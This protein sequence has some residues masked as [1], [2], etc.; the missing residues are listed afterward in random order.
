M[1]FAHPPGKDS[2]RWPWVLFV[3]L[4]AVAVVSFGLRSAAAGGGEAPHKGDKKETPPP[5]GDKKDSPPPQAEKP[6]ANAQPAPTELDGLIELMEEMLKS[7]KQNP[8]GLTPEELQRI[9]QKSMQMPNRLPAPGQFGKLPGGGGLG[10]VQNVYVQRR[11]GA[12]VKPPSDTLSEQLNLPKGQG[13]VIV[14]V[15][16]NSSAAQAGLKP[17]DILLELNGQPVSSN[18]VE[19]AA[20]LAG[21]KSDQP[22]DAVVLRKGARQE[23]KGIKLTETP[24]LPPVAPGLP[25]N[26]FPPAGFPGPGKVIPVGPGQVLPGLPMQPGQG[27]PGGVKPLAPFGGFFEGE[28]TCDAERPDVR[29]GGYCDPY[30]LLHLGSSSFGKGATDA[31]PHPVSHVPDCVHRW[32]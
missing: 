25:K 8:G 16:P 4:I 19:F 32:R 10:G 11:L 13:Q 2:R 5:K 29:C 23:V 14:Q 3:A 15:M 22:V 30:N 28:K 17:A 1:N 7:L 31:P 24:L 21:I 12:Q 20:V 6:P 18:P 27:L 26:P 9:M